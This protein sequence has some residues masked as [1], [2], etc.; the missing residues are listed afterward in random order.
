MCNTK[1]IQLTKDMPKKKCSIPGCDDQHYGR[2]W[3]SK[4]YYRWKTYGSPLQTNK[5]AD[6]TKIKRC[7]TKGCMEL[8]TIGGFCKEHYDVYRLA[9]S[10]EKMCILNG[11]NKPKAV[12]GYCRTHYYGWIP[13]RNKSVKV[14]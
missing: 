5:V 9:K 10:R 12:N 2:G 13:R 14:I 11:C 8:A 4:H 6:T 7:S 1:M 3:C